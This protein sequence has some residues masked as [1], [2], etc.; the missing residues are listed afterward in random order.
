VGVTSTEMGHSNSGTTSNCDATGDNGLPVAS[1]YETPDVS[2]NGI[3][4][5]QGRLYQADGRYYYDINTDASAAELDDLKTWFAAASHIGE[6]GSQIEMSAAPAGWAFDPANAST[7]AG[8]LRDAGSVLVLFFVQD[9]PDQTPDDVASDIIAKIAAAKATCGGFNCVVGGGFVRESC[10]PQVPLGQ[11]I[12]S[13]S[14]E[15]ILDTLPDEDDVT[16]AHFESLLRDTLADVIGQ[17][18]AMIP[19]EG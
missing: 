19:P 2:N 7:N 18:C 10:L 12:D 14:N 17:T 5:A 11:L 16:P 15:A 8:F 3:N 13:M 9:E 6:N 4:G 1:F